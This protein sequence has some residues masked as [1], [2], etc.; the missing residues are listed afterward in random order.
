[1]FIFFINLEERLHSSLPKNST[2]CTTF[3]SSAGKNS[4]SDFSA[5]EINLSMRDGAKSVAL[6]YFF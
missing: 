6:K 1:M 5:E 3:Q 2:V 4:V